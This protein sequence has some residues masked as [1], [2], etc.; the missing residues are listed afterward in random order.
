MGVRFGSHCPP[1]TLASS[2]SDRIGNSGSRISKEEQADMAV[3][4][5]RLA[6]R[7]IDVQ[8]V[9]IAAALHLLER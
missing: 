7:S 2:R 8:L 4:A 5:D 9:M 3:L 6:E 1:E